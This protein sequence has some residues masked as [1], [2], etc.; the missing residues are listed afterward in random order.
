MQTADAFQ[1]T[2]HNKNKDFWNPD[3]IKDCNMVNTASKCKIET[4]IQSAQARLATCTK[5]TKITQCRTRN[6]PLLRQITTH[7]DADNI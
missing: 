4:N 5:W 7:I 1:T 3:Q 2:Q 6:R